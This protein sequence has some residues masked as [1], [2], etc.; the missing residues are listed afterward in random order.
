MQC[1]WNH[2]DKKEKMETTLIRQRIRSSQRLSL[3]P[4]SLPKQTVH[5]ACGIISKIDSCLSTQFPVT[6][7][8]GPKLAVLLKPLRYSQE[9]EGNHGIIAALP[10]EADRGVKGRIP[11]CRDCSLE[12]MI[13]KFRLP[14]GDQESPPQC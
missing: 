11:L 10:R 8:L 2:F 7:V 9:L 13:S 6:L 1:E 14:T 5:H 3:D 4:L 12:E